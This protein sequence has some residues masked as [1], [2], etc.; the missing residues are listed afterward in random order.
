M[1]FTED[2]QGILCLRLDCRTKHLGPTT[3]TPSSQGAINMFYV[4]DTQ[5]WSSVLALEALWMSHQ[6]LLI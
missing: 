4:Y 6:I 1:L 3:N 5:C 2:S